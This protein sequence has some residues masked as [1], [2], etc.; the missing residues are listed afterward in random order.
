MRLIVS[1]VPSLIRN[2]WDIDWYHQLHLLQLF[3]CDN[4]IFL[5]VYK[6]QRYNQ[7]NLSPCPLNI[8]KTKGSTHAY[9]HFYR[10]NNLFFFIIVIRAI[11]NNSLNSIAYIQQ[12]TNNYQHVIQRISNQVITHFKKPNYHTTIHTIV[13]CLSIICPS[14]LRISECTPV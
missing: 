14:Y 9:N 10:R 2:T 6:H 13:A 5:N 12:S 3:C 8:I 7:H 4:F 1:L 11:C